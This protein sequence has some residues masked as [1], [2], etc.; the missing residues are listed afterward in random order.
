MGVQVATLTDWVQRTEGMSNEQFGD[1]HPGTYLVAMGVLSVQMTSGGGE[2]QTFEMFRSPVAKHSGES[3]AL[4]GHVFSVLSQAGDKYTLGREASC[5][6]MVPDPSVSGTH[7][8]LTF[9]D[10]AELV[11]VKD[12]GSRNGTSINNEPIP[13]TAEAVKIEDGDLLTVGRY[14]FQYFGP[15]TFHAALKILA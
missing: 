4:A 13:A 2:L 1:A 15:N 11:T 8:Q 7:C 3:P 12:L 5:D 14:S 6:I 10:G 9:H